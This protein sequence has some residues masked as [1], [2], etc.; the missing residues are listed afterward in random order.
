[1]PSS[2][3]GDDL[4]GVLGPAEGTRVVVGFGQEAVDGGLERDNGVEGATFEVSLAQ[5]GEEA[6]DW[7][8]DCP[9]LVDGFGAWLTTQPL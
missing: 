8:W 5:L 3:G 2:D 7:D 9:G 6:F 4:V 1:M